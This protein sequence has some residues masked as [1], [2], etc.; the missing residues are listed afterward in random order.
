MFSQNKSLNS[1]VGRLLVGVIS[2]AILLL[3]TAMLG[4][5]FSLGTR[6]IPIYGIFLLSFFIA[7]KPI[8][9]GFGSESLRILFSWLIALGCIGTASAVLWMATAP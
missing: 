5:Q 2:L 9:F 4:R 1:F 8:Y 3:I 6:L 7:G